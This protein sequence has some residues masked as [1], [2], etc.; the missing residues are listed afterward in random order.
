MKTL[1]KILKPFKVINLED[2]VDKK[3]FTYDFGDFWFDT[4]GLKSLSELKNH[5]FPETKFPRSFTDED[6]LECINKAYRDAEEQSYMS[7]YIDRF[8]KR[9]LDNLNDNE[10]F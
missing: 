5:S 4:P 1:E 10:D 6:K 8:H 9:L 7:D 3:L 2:Y